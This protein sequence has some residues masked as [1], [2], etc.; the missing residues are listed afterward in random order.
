[1]IRTGSTLVLLLL[2][3][4]A[5]AQATPSEPP[6]TTPS[7]P[8]QTPP[9][10]DAEGEG[11]IVGGHDA[12]PNSARWQVEIYS[13][14]QFT[15]S[16]EVAD[17]ALPAGDPN[18]RHLDVIRENWERDHRCGGALIAPGWVLTAGHCV[19]ARFVPGG[20][21]QT[22]RVRLGSIS[23]LPGG[24]SVSYRIQS[25]V[26]HKDFDPVTLTY[27]I[28]LLRIVR[29]G[30]TARIA[31]KRFAPIS[32]LSESDR[33]VSADDEVTTTGWGATSAR[34][35]GAPMALAADGS[36]ERM[37]PTLKEL[38]LSVRNI[39]ACSGRGME[40][41]GAAIRVGR[42]LCVLPPPGT[43]DC[44]GD[45]GGP[46]VRAE[47]GGK[48][49]LVGLVSQGRGCA[50]GRPSLYTKV[51]EYRLWIA[52]AKRNSIRGKLINR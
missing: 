36:V 15:K 50:M 30:Q 45:S 38:S 47:G 7:D 12:Q 43:G 49:V 10:V 48:F 21:V 25:A 27:D 5:L 44:N 39:A 51:S 13:T 31:S 28:A 26:L 35:P 29:D 16:E 33:P 4:A 6:P 24:G 18:K 11:R 40:A 17:A 42:V 46:L 2:A 20:V 14:D 3:Q 41:Y 19:H 37:S 32:P 34:R 22:R 23:L 52:D 9:A 8:P 1:M